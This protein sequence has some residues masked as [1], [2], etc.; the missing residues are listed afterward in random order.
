M[1]FSTAWFSVCELGSPGAEGSDPLSCTDAKAGK[2]LWRCLHR[3][4][5]TGDYAGIAFQRRDLSGFSG[6]TS[7][8][9]P[10]KEEDDHHS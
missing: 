2:S 6:T 10:E 7:P 3:Y 1:P 5:K 8:D 4:W 9:A